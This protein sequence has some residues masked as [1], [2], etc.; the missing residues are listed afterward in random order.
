MRL[1]LTKTRKFTV[2][3]YPAR[4]LSTCPC[5]TF[6]DKTAIDIDFRALKT[7]LVGSLGT[8]IVALIYW[9]VQI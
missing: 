2:R 5:L 6:S 3:T 4:S 9:L 7:Y 8:G 1:S